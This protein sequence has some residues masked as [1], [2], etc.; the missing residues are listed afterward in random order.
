MARIEIQPVGSVLGVDKDGYIVSSSAVEK[1]QAK[2]RE[3]A[4]AVVEVCRRVLGE[5]LHSVYVRGSASR[6][7]AID[8][9][10][11]LDMMVVVREYLGEKQKS[12][13]DSVRR[14][15]EKCYPF[16]RGIETS[17]KLLEPLESRQNPNWF[18]IKVYS[19]CVY[20]QDLAN[21]L[22]AVKPGRSM[23]LHA[24][25]VREELLAI[26]LKFEN[27]EYAFTAGRCVWMMKRLLR[28]GAELVMERE[29]G[30]TRDLYYC[31]SLFS[32]YYPDKE[33]EMRQVLELA[34]NPVGEMRQIKGLVVQLAE[35]IGDEVGRVYGADNNELIRSDYD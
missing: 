10:S 2:W 1:M 29:Q 19:V 18:L 9:M 13:L 22:P 5:N 11:D 6:G 27:G 7:E 23:V 21:V 28:S 25:D 14:N 3:A 35:W 20:G 12:E 33:P 32:K 4:E 15:L 17:V 26:I 24:L 31:Y 34:L 16:C 8:G 30:Y